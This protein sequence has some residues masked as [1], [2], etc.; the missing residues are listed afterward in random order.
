MLN[1][2]FLTH[3][4]LPLG[5]KA[6]FSLTNIACHGDRYIQA[7]PNNVLLP[8][9]S[10]KQLIE[11]SYNQ[12]TDPSSIGYLEFVRSEDPELIKLGL[13]YLQL[14]LTHVPEVCAG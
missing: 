13:T 9:T 10:G 8:G 4:D 1:R 12:G 14:L 5:N 7:L 3:T 11:S 6:A 2:L